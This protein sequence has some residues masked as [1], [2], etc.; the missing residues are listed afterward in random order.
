MSREVQVAMH[1]LELILQNNGNITADAVRDLFEI[2]AGNK[3][4]IVDHLK[5]ISKIINKAV[6]ELEGDDL[7][8]QIITVWKEK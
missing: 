7:S 2:H 5:A 3:Q 4:V 8:E 6:E 1:F